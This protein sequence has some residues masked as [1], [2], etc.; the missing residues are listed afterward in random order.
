M[1]QFI[2]L[3][4]IILFSCEKDDICADTTQTTP[5]L[6]IEFYDLTAPDKELAVAGLY[7]LGLDTDAL[8]VPITNEIVMTRTSIT[9]PLKTDDFETEF[10][11]YK[12]YDIVDG[13]VRGNPDVI[14]VTHSTENLYISRACGYITNFEIQ[15]FSIAEDSD[16]WM[17]NSE[18]LN[19]EITNENE[20]H[21]KIFH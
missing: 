1:K 10:V 5:R 9:L 4:L 19:Y 14:K 3:F 20:I 13:V 16:Q 12:N 15:T 7:A 11:L 17:R 8:E 18:I 21:V 6:V 2:Y